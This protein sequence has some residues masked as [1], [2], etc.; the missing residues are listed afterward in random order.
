MHLEDGSVVEGGRLRMR[1]QWNSASYSPLQEKHQLQD[2]RIHKNRLSGFWEG[3]ASEEVLTSHGIRTLLFAGA[4][5]DQCVGASL[6][7]AFTKGWDCLLL[8]DGC[9]TT[10]P[11]FA[12]QCIEFNSE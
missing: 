2:I 12:K 5:T 3:T 6:Q 8:S 4:N 9:A 7:D 11:K 10:S 1:D